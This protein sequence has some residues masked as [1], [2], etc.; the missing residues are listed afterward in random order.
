MKAKW[1][2]PWTCIWW[3]WKWRDFAIG[4]ARSSWLLAGLRF[5]RPT[6]LWSFLQC[7]QRAGQQSSQSSAPCRNW[8]Y[9]KCC[10]SFSWASRPLWQLRWERC[11]SQF[12][13][14][15]F[16][17]PSCTCCSTEPPFHL[18]EHESSLH[19]TT[20]LRVWFVRLQTLSRS[21][22]VER[23]RQ[24]A[25]W[26]LCKGRPGFWTYRANSESLQ[27]CLPEE[28]FEKAF[29]ELLPHFSSKGAQSPTIT[30]S[31]RCWAN[32]RTWWGPSPFA[33]HRSSE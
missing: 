5:G 6:S 18:W 12:G 21:E 10:L 11:T 1:L 20:W 29:G 22:F 33:S 28:S 26:L 23:S 14:R 16:Q 8:S 25:A 7:T 4:I 30:S 32:I 13:W 24:R 27:S 31:H 17:W 3:H 15:G 9:Y 19:R 2:P